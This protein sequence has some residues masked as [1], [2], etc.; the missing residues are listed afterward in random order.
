MVNAEIGEIKLLLSQKNPKATNLSADPYAKAMIYTLKTPALDNIEFQDV[1]AYKDTI[2]NLF[3]ICRL[4]EVQLFSL[5]ENTISPSLWSIIKSS[6]TP[7]EIFKKLIT[8][9]FDS[10]VVNLLFDKLHYIVQTDFE[11]IEDYFCS[12]KQ[13]HEEIA[14]IKS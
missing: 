10:K 6:E 2:I 11:R 3:K 4:N 5:L 7:V 1:I 8:H 13:V 9:S 14:N 12:I